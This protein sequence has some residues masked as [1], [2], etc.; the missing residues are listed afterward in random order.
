MAT[1]DHP[2]LRPLSGRRVEHEGLSYV[3]L[4][5][6]AGVFVEPVLVPLEAFQNVVRH[7]DGQTSLLAIQ[8]RILRES[9]Q[10]VSSSQLAQLVDQLDRAHVLDGPAFAEFVTQYHAQTSRPAALAG[11]SY[12]ASERALRAELLRYFTAEGG[13]GEP[14]ECTATNLRGILCPHIDFGRGGPVYGSAYKALVE[15]SDAEVFVIFGVA[16]QACRRRFV[17]TRKDFET[18]LG[19]AV[20][21]R[22]YVDRIVEV[23][24]E[25]YFDDELAHRTEHSIEFQTVFLRHLL[26]G[27]RSFA[28]VPILIGSFQDLM[29]RG[30]DPI[31]DPEVATFVQ[32]LKHAEAGCTRKVAYIGGIDLCHVGP[33]FG[34]ARPVDELMLK[35]VA[36]FDDGMLT[37]ATAA[38]PQAWF[39]QAAQIQNA[40]RVCGLAATYVMLHAIGEVEGRRLRYDQ[41][42][43][44]E[45][46]GCVTFA[47]VSYHTV[48]PK[49]HPEAATP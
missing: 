18:P 16:H 36:E 15:E 5:D 9:G 43:N 22:S 46:T 49:T 4:V 13:A 38:D 10:F 12:S 32:A 19:T 14:G 23:A 42:V 28:I 2:R 45:K 39:A 37:N 40:Y 48:N 24:G 29:E 7:F 44:A 30:I 8:A 20:T 21:D 6:P 31:A 47:G 3:A 17:M 35:T 34:D 11:R 33:E 26:G 27:K 41:A 1:L 25:A